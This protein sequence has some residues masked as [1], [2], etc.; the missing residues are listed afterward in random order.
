MAELKGLLDD[1]NAESS[2]LRGEIMDRDAKVFE[3]EREARSQRVR[4]Q[5][6]SEPPLDGDTDKKTS[7]DT[8]EKRASHGASAGARKTVSGRDAASSVS[9]TTR[10]SCR[11]RGITRKTIRQ[12]GP[13]GY[14]LA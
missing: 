2:R 3:L 4:E 14:P 7:R 11:S 10:G 12:M 8:D 5:Q 13:L 1:A 9:S 6:E